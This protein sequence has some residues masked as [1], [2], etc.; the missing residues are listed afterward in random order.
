[1]RSRPLPRRALPSGALV[2]LSAAFGVSSI[3]SPQQ[4]ADVPIEKMKVRASHA[5]R[6]GQPSRPDRRPALGS[7]AFSYYERNQIARVRDL[8]LVIT[9]HTNRIWRAGSKILAEIGPDR[10]D[11]ISPLASLKEA[12]VPFCLASD[13]APVSMFNTIW[14]CVARKDRFTNSVIGPGQMISREEALRAAT[15]NGAYLT[16]EENEKRSIESA[17]IFAPPQ[18]KCIAPPRTKNLLVP[19]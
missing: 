16:F 7:G 15:I 18:V 10:E 12:G 8:G 11:Q 9:T 13:N 4:G 3:A 2:R 5:L 14:Q 1:M 17:V 6:R 19:L